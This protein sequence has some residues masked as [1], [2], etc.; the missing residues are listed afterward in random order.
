MNLRTTFETF[1]RYSEE[2]IEEIK[3]GSKFKDTMTPWNHLNKPITIGQC[4][5]LYKLLGATNSHDFAIK[6]LDSGDELQ[7]LLKERPK[8]EHPILKKLHGRTEAEFL[9]VAHKFLAKLDSTQ[10][11]LEEVI[12]YMWLRM[13]YQTNTGAQR[14]RLTRQAL[15]VKFPH[16][17]FKESSAELDTNYGIDLECYQG[18]QLICGIQIKPE[19]YYFGQSPNTQSAKYQNATKHQRYSNHYQVPVKYVIATEE[20]ELVKIYTSSEPQTFRLLDYEHPQLLNFNPFDSRK[21]TY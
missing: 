4:L 9:N 14:E 19:S 5:H 6:Y 10:Y 3:E 8:S 13:F 17:Y 1:S 16:F 15:R 2:T 21:K 11:T 12:L 20:G 7:A 18:D